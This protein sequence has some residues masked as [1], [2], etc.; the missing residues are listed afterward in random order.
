MTTI[1]IV[2][3]DSFDGDCS[4]SDIIKAFADKGAAEVFC[5]KCDAE[6]KRVME[7]VKAHYEKHREELDEISKSLTALVIK[8][9][10]KKIMMD[11]SK[12]P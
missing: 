11:Y 10:K 8:N 4:Y 5:N 2:V 12:V 7:E 1:Y 9:S 3:S 6:T